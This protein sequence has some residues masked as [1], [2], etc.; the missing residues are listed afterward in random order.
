MSSNHVLL[1]LIE[2]WAKF[3]ENKNVVGTV[4]LDLSKAFDS[5]PHDLLA[6]KLHGY[7]LSEDAITFGQKVA[8]VVNLKLV[9]TD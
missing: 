2:N 6:E 5:I 4:L 3:R 8:R 1:R 9:F 7:G